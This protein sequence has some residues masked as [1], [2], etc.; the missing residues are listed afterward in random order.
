M[1]DRNKKGLC[2]YCGQQKKLTSDHVPPKRLLERPFPPNLW[3]VKACSDCNQSFMADDEYT[4]TVLVRDIRANWNYAAQINLQNI[5][6]SLERPEAKLFGNYL[7]RQSEQM[8]IVS[9]SGAAIN[10]ID[11]D[12]T[13]INRTGMHIV[14]GL[15]FRETGKVLPSNAAVHI[16]ST[17][18]LD[19]GHPAL[20]TFANLLVTLP[21]HRDG[22]TGTAFSYYSAFNDRYSAWGLMLYDFFFWL[23]TTDEG[24]ETN[25]KGQQG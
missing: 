20:T 9:A 7:A 1:S 6:R 22:A 11:I 14:R 17:T 18:G 24:E 25:E 8:R 10:T 2:A 19:S 12:K 3:V 23:A 21:N 16:G 5:V 15:Y 13:R 4:A